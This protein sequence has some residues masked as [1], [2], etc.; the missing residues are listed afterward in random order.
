MIL[1][2]Y[3]IQ[4]VIVSYEIITIV[5]QIIQFSLSEPPAN[6]KYTSKYHIS[7]NAQLYLQYKYFYEIYR[8]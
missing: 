5:L 7:S 8:I 3:E 1:N 6:G 2:D 4:V